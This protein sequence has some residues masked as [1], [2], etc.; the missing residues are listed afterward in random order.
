MKITKRQ[1]KRI[2]NEEY[3]RIINE[4]RLK[5]IIK[6]VVE[7]ELST[8][9]PSSAIMDLMSQPAAESHGVDLDEIFDMWGDAGMDVLDS[10]GASLEV[11]G[12]LWLDEEEGRVYM[13]GTPGFYRAQDDRER[14]DQLRANIDQSVGLGPMHQRGNFR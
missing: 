8:K 14:K 6:E 1:L 2:I 3:N 10:L 11:D 9:D 4:I 7:N 13:Q 5:R 12:P